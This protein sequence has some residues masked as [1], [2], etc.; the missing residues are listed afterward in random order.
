MGC[1][2][3]IRK[4]QSSRLA[5]IFVLVSSVT[6]HLLTISKGQE[7][8]GDYGLY[9]GHAIN[10][11]TGNS[12]SDTG[13]IYNP[14]EPFLS[15]RSYPPVYP[16][17][18]SPVYE[19]FGLDLYA[20][21]VANVLVFV[22]FLILFYRYTKPRLESP[23]SQVMVVAAVA[24]SPWFWVAKDRILPD[25][26][27]IL[28]VFLAV[29]IMDRIALP[30]K[31]NWR[32]MSLACAAG[33]VAYLSYGT[34]SL[35]LTVIPALVFSDLARFRKVSLTTFVATCIFLGLY[36]TQNAILHTDQSYAAGILS[37]HEP[38]TSVQNGLQASPGQ[39]IDITKLA[40]KF[41]DT[42]KFNLVYYHKVMVSY[43][44]HEISS[45]LQRITYVVVG[46]LAFI[47]FLALITR[48]PSTGDY[49][50]LT[51][52]AAVVLLPFLLGGRYLLPIIPL[53]ILY[54]FRGAEI[55]GLKL[56]RLLE[57]KWIQP[58]NAL[59]IVVTGMIALSYVTSYYWKGFHD[60]ATGV[61]TR[62]SQEMFDFI[63]E[64][65]PENSVIIFRKPR[66]LAL[67]TG[68]RSARYHWTRNVEDLQEYFIRIGATHFIMVADG[69]GV[70]TEKPYLDW[71]ERYASG[72]VPV[73]TSEHFRIYRF[74]DSSQA[75]YQ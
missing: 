58:A 68:R 48:K 19:A 59:V 62:E 5:I 2:S 42:A 24:Y 72:Q 29:V 53:Y 12:Y 44:A 64:S 32:K 38:V 46:L 55:A 18:L 63:Q 34:R 13:F 57:N 49:F 6:F 69:S 35:G 41:L 75:G 67:F 17:F 50:L 37:T 71:F 66:P 20:M 25:I 14:K 45:V 8:G 73:Y 51:Y 30:G 31:L 56:G 16:L 26:L 65:T 60:Y 9:I 3:P 74:H 28:L 21:Q 61:G 52:G 33:V 11:V 1:F 27:F 4:I 22:L 54:I 15:P 43:W 40:H 23:V 36:L 39:H 70:P 10:I 47:G 7:W